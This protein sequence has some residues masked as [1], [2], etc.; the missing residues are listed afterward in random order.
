[1]IDVS[2]VRVTLDE[3]SPENQ[4]GLASAAARALGVKA[5]EIAVAGLAKR[6]IDARKK[7]DVHFVATLEVSCVDTALEERI[8]AGN[9]KLAPGVNV[10]KHV[11]FEPLNIADLSDNWAASYRLA[12]TR[13]VVVGFGPAGMFAALYLA[14]AGLRP[15]VL[16][17]GGSIEER[18]A[19]VA[20]F[21]DGAP[22][23]ATTNI[24]FGEGGAGTFSDGKLNTGTKSPL[25]RHVLQA[26]VDA[27]A[28]EE[29]L[30]EAKPHIGTDKLVD[31]VR[32]IRKRIEELG[33][34]VRFH[35][36]LTGFS[37]LSGAL[38]AAITEDTKP[39]PIPAPVVPEDKRVATYNGRH[40]MR[41]PARY[42][43]LACGHSARDT[44]SVLKD[45]GFALEQK[46]F[47]IG[48]RIEHPQAAI[49]ATQ[50]GDA[51]GHPALPAADYKLVEHLPNGR[52]VYTFCMCPG[53]S[54]VCAASEACGVVVNGMSRFARDG[55][56]ANAA[57][58]VGV[59]PDDFPGDDPLA[60]VA[61][62]EQ[63]EH[64]AYRIAQEAG[65]GMYQAPAQ[66]VGDFLAGTAG[67]PSKEVTPSYARGVAWC[68]LRD[69]L[70]GFVADSIAQALPALG[71]KLHGFDDPE[72]VMTGV[73]TRSSS[74]VRIVRD[75]D[76]LNAA[77]LGLGDDDSA[78][79]N[80]YPCGEG[81]GYAGGIMSAAV[82]GLRCAMA[83]VERLSEPLPEEEDEEADDEWDAYW[84]NCPVD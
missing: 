61:L 39:D 26:F 6:S 18:M 28:P 64:A 32:N 71:R 40:S 72:A 57:L 4:Q 79:S 76:T 55:E 38:A 42:L 37:I 24:Q 16:E 22:L 49:D 34:E 35:T 75:D 23:D 5:E 43:V 58:L 77:L 84:T 9:A 47:S 69:C 63:V 65:D 81:A 52:G 45:A 29:I 31:V 2:N 30:W 46:P 11:P 10:K 53:G 21:E 7:R 13:P 74:P 60:G 25:A 70:P 78:F 1:M 66:T 27:G 59:S 54:V 82:D 36:K 12:N 50:Y 20:S 68:D 48:V 51:A 62:Q 14:E 44:F 8:L 15:V 41:L 17:R 73:E 56:N 33:G 67:A 80:I 3:G 83:I 19:A